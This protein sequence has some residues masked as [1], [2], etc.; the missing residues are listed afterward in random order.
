MAGTAR[1]ATFAPQLPLPKLCPGNR[2]RC[3][4]DTQLS[5]IYLFRMCEADDVPVTSRQVAATRGG[6]WMAWRAMVR[7]AAQVA[8][9]AAQQRPCGARQRPGGA[10]IAASAS[11]RSGPP[12]VGRGA[13]IGDR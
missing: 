7:T 13:G 6:P 5:R 8:P 10:V 12:Q 9:T 2:L 4:I 11:R 3:P 1:A